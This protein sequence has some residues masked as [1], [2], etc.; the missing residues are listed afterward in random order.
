MTLEE[1]LVIKSSLL[2]EKDKPFDPTAGSLFTNNNPK[3]FQ[4]VLTYPAERR[5]VVTFQHA[6]DAVVC[7]RKFHRF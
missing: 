3:F 6:K 7:R 1:S 4:E 2:L 5:A